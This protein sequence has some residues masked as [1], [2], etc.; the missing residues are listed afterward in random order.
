MPMGELG[1]YQF[2]HRGS[3]PIGA[4]MPLVPQAERS[5][6]NFY[7]AVDDI[8][9]AAEAVLAH[10]G[11]LMGEAQEVPGGSYA[12]NAIDPAGAPIGLVGPRKEQA[13]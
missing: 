5:C 12:L 1:E 4:I 3:A 7:I 9:R 11:S 13:A 8:D 6:W 2:I 10:G